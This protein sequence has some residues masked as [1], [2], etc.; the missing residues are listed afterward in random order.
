MNYVYVCVFEAEVALFPLI[1]VGF[2]SFICAFV[3][4]GKRHTQVIFE[5]SFQLER[6]VKPINMT[7]TI[8][9]LILREEGPLSRALSTLS[10][11]YFHI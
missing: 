4:Q 10:L 5:P 6:R 11:K 9:N 7:F 3:S 2:G 8:N 1:F